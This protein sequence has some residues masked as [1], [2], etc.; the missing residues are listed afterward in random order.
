MHAGAARSSPAKPPASH[1]NDSGL[2][3][4]HPSLLRAALFP[5]RL[6]KVSETHIAAWL[7]ACQKAGLVVLYTSKNEAFL[8]LLQFRQTTR[9]KPE[10]PLP[11][12]DQLQAAGLSHGVGEGP[13]LPSIGTCAAVE[14]K[15]GSSDPALPAD[16]QQLRA[17]DH[18]GVFVFED[19]VVCGAS[20]RP[21]QAQVPAMAKII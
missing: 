14:N 16:A 7:K 11:T 4:A 20:G 19:V 1:V 13:V 15:D 9:S 2:A 10:F 12:A 18:L 17:N 6:A 5:L 8:Q 3:T 21:T